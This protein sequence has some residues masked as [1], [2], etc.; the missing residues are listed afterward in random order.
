V[1]LKNSVVLITGAS[2][3]IGEA[4][5]LAFAKKGARLALCARHLDR[6]QAV[7]KRCREAGSPKVTTKRV[8][9]T[10]RTEARAF[11]AAALRDFDRIDILVNNAG[12]GWAGPL[13]E[14]PEEK[15]RALVDT[16]LLG[17][18]W[19]T[20]P[21]LTAMIAVRSGVIINVSS[22]SGVRATPYSALY[23][24]TKHAVTGLSHALRGELSGTGV[25]VCAVYP[26][27]TESDFFSVSGGSPVGPVYPAS[28]VA[29]LIVRT[30]RFPRRDAMV[31]PF[32]L[33][34]LA[35]PF[36]GGLI[37]HVAGEMRR[38]AEPGASR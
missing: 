18:L 17:L 6:L 10:R 11:V 35:E 15:A 1:R 13:I 26:A 37:D 36:L 30:A 22:I 19:T 32:R 33:A 14:M 28:W 2:S 7:A 9:V 20:Q 34:H 29:N 8:D 5:A 24:A 12:L 23:S 31:F 16:N 27:V 38:K 25:K 3:G 21:A 4:T